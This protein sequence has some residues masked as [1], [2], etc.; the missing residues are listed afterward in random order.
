MLGRPAVD[1]PENLWI[2]CPETGEMVFHKELEANKWVIPGSGYH[3]KMPAKE[4]LADL[5]DNGD[6]EALTQPKVAQDPLKFRDNKKYADRLRDARTKTSLEDTIVAGVGK[7]RGVKMVAVVH[8]FEF[9]G[10]SLGMAAGEAIIKAFE[11]AIAE[12]CPLVIFPAS[13]G[14][15]M[16][17]G[18]LSL[19]QLPR[20]TVA[21]EL[22]KE[23]GQPYF[24]V[25][26]NPTTGGVTASYAM[27]GDVH[28][29]EP[30]AEIGFAGKRVIEQTI[31]EKLPEGF[32][33][34]EY[35]MQH[36]MV[37]MVVSRLEM[38][39]T[40]ARLL[41]M[42]LKLPQGEKPLEPEILPPAIA[43]PET[44]PKA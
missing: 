12:A 15:R 42:L 30:G 20:T 13:G 29:A 4:R 8:E 36:G 1:T 2:K 21:V 41:K 25:L 43:A 19:M 44:P 16:Q 28:L 31:R 9:I 14:A 5:F 37:D 10:G 7:V 40:I 38:R 34:S 39:A 26:T 6:Y 3:M 18:I 35:L 22:L 24:V 23:A 33:R 11:R 27:L 17:E 32:Q